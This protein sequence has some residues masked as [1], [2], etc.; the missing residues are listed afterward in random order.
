MAGPLGGA[1]VTPRP[2]R[3]MLP[4]RTLQILHDYWTALP[5]TDGV[6]DVMK[7]DPAAIMPAL[8]YVALLDVID[9][10]RDYYYSLYGSKIAN[11]S[12]FDMTHKHLGEIPT[13]ADVRLF[14]R[15]GYLAVV[16]HHVPLYAV[17][18]APEHI[19]IGWWHRLILPIGEAGEV[20]RL[21]VGIIPVR[22]DDA[23]SG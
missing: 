22:N 5:K 4:Y 16:R 6:A 23:R 18:L 2:D 9:D 13:T 12:G 8:G 19:T 21:L 20:K 15:A 10:G 17:H 14:F 1:T 11:V 3:S 7:V